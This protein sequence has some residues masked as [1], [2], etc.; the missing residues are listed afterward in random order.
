MAYGIERVTAIGMTSNSTV[1]IPAGYYIEH[2][3]MIGTNANAVTGGIKVGTTNG[4]VDVVLALAIAGNSLNFVT[5]ALLL[6]R[7]FSLTVDTTLYLQ[8]VTGWNSA[9]VNAYFICK[10]LNGT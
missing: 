10:P 7:I 3:C 4:G 9:S 6:K 2:V 5:D 8:A 1:V